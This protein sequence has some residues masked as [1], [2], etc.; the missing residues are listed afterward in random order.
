MQLLLLSLNLGPNHQKQYNSVLFL[1]LHQHSSHLDLKAFYTTRRFILAY[2]LIEKF[3]KPLLVFDADTII[4]KNLAEYVASNINVDI[5]ISIK[6]TG[7]YF[8]LTISAHQT[9]FNN[10]VNSKIFLKF[11]TVTKL[12]VFFLLKISQLCC[13]VE[14]KCT[15]ILV[16]AVFH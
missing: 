5:A 8:H 16:Q 7:R 6:S 11:P 12:F 10:T 14:S 15:F 9:L 1:E 3:S 2:D 4:N 13:S